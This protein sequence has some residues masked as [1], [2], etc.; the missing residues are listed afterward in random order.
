M[1]DPAWENLG[2]CTPFP[3]PS[4]F[5]YV[6]VV[7]YRTLAMH[8]EAV[9]MLGFIIKADLEDAEEHSPYGPPSLHQPSNYI[10]T[11]NENS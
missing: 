10:Y 3:H 1:A 5:N 8:R 6:C 9:F 2:K 4:T 11:F 7:P